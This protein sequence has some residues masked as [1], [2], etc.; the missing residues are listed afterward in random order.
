MKVVLSVLLL[1]PVFLF[2]QVPIALQSSEDAKNTEKIYEDVD[3]SATFPGGTVEMMKY[4]SA[5]V[6]YPESA[7]DNG[8]QGKVFVEFVIN[9]DGSISNIKILKGISRDLDTEAMRVVKNM[10]KWTPALLDGEKVRSV[11]RMP[12]NFVL[13]E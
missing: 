7:M 6:K 10:P 1:I 8:E 2:S 3:E 9:K 11:A 12:I 4:I 5:N 13:T